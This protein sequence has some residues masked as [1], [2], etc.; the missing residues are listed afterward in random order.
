MGHHREAQTFTGRSPGPPICHRH[1]R[2]HGARNDH[3]HSQNFATASIPHQA[4]AEL[5]RRK[6]FADPRAFRRAGLHQFSRCVAWLEAGAGAED[7]VSRPAAASFKHVN[8]AG[9]GLGGENLDATFSARTFPSRLGAVAVGGRLPSRAAGRSHRLIWR[10]HRLERHDRPCDG[11]D[12]QE[13]GVRRR[14]R[15]RLDADA[16]ALLREKRDGRFIVLTI[17]P[18]YE[19]EGVEVRDE[20]GLTLVQDRD[21]SDA[22]SLSASQIVTANR[23]LP[24]AASDDLSLAMIVARHTQSNAVVLA[25]NGRPS[26][27]AQGS[28]HASL[29]PASPARRRKPR[30]CRTIRRSSTFNSGPGSGVSRR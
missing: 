6:A 30:C 14:D 20:F 27:S 1:I 9:V 10:F 15:P 24:T 19:P 22:P 13:R 26:A 8:P 28:S 17:D 25:A 7:S 3:G 18:A 11:A 21:I 2:H 16:L 5:R 4:F 23:H 29:R 12:H